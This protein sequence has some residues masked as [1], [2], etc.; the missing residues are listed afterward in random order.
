MDVEGV[1]DDTVQALVSTCMSGLTLGA[2][3]VVGACGRASVIVT[4][5]I[6]S[7]GVTVL[8][9]VTAGGFAAS[10][11]FGASVAVG[12]ARISVG[13]VAA[14]APVDD[15]GAE[16]AMLVSAPSSGGVPERGD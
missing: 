9:Q 3:A 11:G 14:T 4:S 6:R 8:A 7:G 15:G 10:A 1:A 13:G 2:T 5:P 12:P 16:S